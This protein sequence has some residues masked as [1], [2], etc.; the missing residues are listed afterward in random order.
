M[1]PER[2][3]VGA[4]FLL[5]LPHSEDHMS[6]DK[7]HQGAFLPDPGEPSPMTFIALDS[8]ESPL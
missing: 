8:R 3:C 1:K 7:I 2:P 6:V 5:E 4:I